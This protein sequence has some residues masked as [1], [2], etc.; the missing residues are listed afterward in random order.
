[1]NVYA[2]MALPGSQLYK[3]ATENGYQLPAEYTGY[4]FHSYDTLPM[5]TEHLTA[6]EIL[7]FRD[8]FYIKY[9]S[10]SKFQER[11]LLKFGEV[12]VNNVNKSLKIVLRRKILEDLEPKQ[13]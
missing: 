10:A 6:A 13:S 2:A 11:L 3:T 1:M 7:K 9:H 12:A 5:Q 8:N 4:S